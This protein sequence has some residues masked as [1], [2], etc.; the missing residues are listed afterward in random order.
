MNHIIEC[1]SNYSIGDHHHRVD[2]TVYS[3]LHVTYIC[4]ISLLLFIPYC[5]HPTLYIFQYST[6]L[7][8]FHTCTLQCTYIHLLLF[9]LVHTLH[10]TFLDTSEFIHTSL[11]LYHS[12]YRCIQTTVC[13]ATSKYLHPQ[14]LFHDQSML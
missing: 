3:L 14:V 1:T 6:K 9:I 2:T 5:I 8:H 7:V 11:C 12:L 13:I 4:F 10:I